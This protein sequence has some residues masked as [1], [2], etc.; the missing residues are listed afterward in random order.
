MN[1]FLSG[2]SLL[3]SVEFKKVFDPN[4]FFYPVESYL[5]YFGFYPYFIEQIV[6]LAYLIVFVLI[7]FFFSNLKRNKYVYIV[8]TFFYLILLLFIYGLT[9][10]E[11]YTFEGFNKTDIIFFS[12]NYF[13][14]CF[15]FSF[16]N[17]YIKIFFVSLAIFLLFF[18]SKLFC[19]V[20]AFRRNFFFVCVCSGF[21]LSLNTCDLI[22]FILSV[23]MIVFGLY[24]FMCSVADGLFLREGLIK[25]FI[26]GSLSSASFWFCAAIMFSSF[27]SSLFFIGLPVLNAGPSLHVGICFII[28]CF[29][30]KLGAAPA[31]QWVIDG[32]DNFAIPIFW[33]LLVFVKFIFLFILIKFLFYFI[34]FSSTFIFYLLVLSSSFSMVVGSMGM[35]KQYNLRRFFL[36]SALQ[37]LGFILLGFL[38][39]LDKVGYFFTINGLFYF[40]SYA[41]GFT[42]LIFLLYL[43]YLK[44]GKELNYSSDLIGLN[45][46]YGYFFLIFFLSYAGVPPFVG[47]WA[48]LDI[49]T[50]AIQKGSIISLASLAFVIPLTSYIYID[51]IKK[52]RIDLKFSAELS[53]L[54]DYNS[55]KSLGIFNKYLLGLFLLLFLLLLFS[56]CPKAL[57][58]LLNLFLVFH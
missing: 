22:V 26:G 57:A 12:L 13:G 46:Y 7:E 17:F 3:F 52:L 48:K 33:F 9:Y 2:L 31:H 20:N 6:L 10:V 32:Y 43:F 39:F 50:I 41:I 42:G 35:F 40:F 49:V 5:R 56:I 25:Y 8:L 18:F 29:F 37:N 14:P 15:F 28:F 58:Y 38:S 44:T 11:I 19:S 54:L 30:L 47:F 53:E 27:K 45:Y 16:S 55:N 4:L 21:L 36:Y 1:K 23:E 24:F 51:F 34:T